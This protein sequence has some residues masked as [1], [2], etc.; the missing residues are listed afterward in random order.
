MFAVYLGY[1][2]FRL[3]NAGASGNNA[4]EFIARRTPLDIAA[5][6]AR[7]RL[8]A[9][10]DFCGVAERAS[11]PVFLLAGV[12]DPVVATWPVL[13]WLRKDCPA[14]KGHR[15]IW[16]A[17]HTVLATEQAKSVEQIEKWIL[18]SRPRF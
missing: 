5:M 16:P 8:I 7:V 10:A 14:F 1:S 3:R 17:D 12:I 13:R 4:K 6:Q 15:I 18:E 11:C 2:G 9:G